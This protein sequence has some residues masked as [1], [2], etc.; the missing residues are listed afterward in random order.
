MEK[1][2]TQNL[3]S[4]TRISFHFNK[5]IQKTV[6]TARKRSLGQGNIFTHVCH[7]VHRGVCMVAGGHVWLLRGSMHGCRGVAC[8]VAGGHVWLQGGMHGCGGHV[9]LLWG[10]CGCWGVCIVVGV[11]MVVG[12]MCRIQ[13]DTVNERAVRILMECILVSI[14]QILKKP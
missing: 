12:G 2:S 7:S 13:Q 14:K 9:W 4:L 5:L 1:K 10:V 3:F 8:M 11:C 6:I